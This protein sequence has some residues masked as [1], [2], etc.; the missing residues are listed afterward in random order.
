[1][2]LFCFIIVFTPLSR[3]LLFAVYINYVTSLSCFEP[4]TT[5]HA[6]C[7]L[8]RERPFSFCGVGAR[9]STELH[10]SF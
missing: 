3:V 5:V 4:V 2:H 10:W 7:T 9:R 8:I 6:H 1:M